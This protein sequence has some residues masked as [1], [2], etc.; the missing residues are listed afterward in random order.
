MMCL[1]S[2]CSALGALASLCMQ[3]ALGRGQYSLG[4]ISASCMVACSLAYAMSTLSLFLPAQESC[5][6][7]RCWLL[8]D[9]LGAMFAQEELIRVLVLC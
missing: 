7:A 4:N 5:H 6:P 1:Q 3:C 2:A 9:V 8:L